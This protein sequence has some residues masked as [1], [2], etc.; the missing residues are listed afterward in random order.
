MEKIA[1]IVTNT[2]GMFNFLW[3]HIDML[4]EMVYKV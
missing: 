2:I 1:L 3:T 4:T